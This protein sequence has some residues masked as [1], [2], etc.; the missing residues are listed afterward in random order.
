MKLTAR[1]YGVEIE[2]KT[3]NGVDYDSYEA[4]QQRRAIASALQAEG[5]NAQSESYNHTTRSYWKLISDAS[6]GHE[7]VSP[8]LRG[9]EGFKEI[10]KVCKVL[11]ALGYKVDKSCG[12]HVHHGANDLSSEQVKAV[13]ALAIK[14]ET[15]IDHLVAPSRKSNQYCRSNNVNR[16]LTLIGTK[17]ALNTLKK[18]AHI[19]HYGS[20]G[21]DRYLKVN[22]TAYLRHGTIEFRQHQGTLDAK[23]IVWWIILTQNFLT[24]AVE[25]GASYTVSASGICFKRFRDMLGST[26]IALQDNAYV[27][28]ASKM[29]LDRWHEFSGSFG[30]YDSTLE[31]A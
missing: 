14:W 30:I 5:I 2:F 19:Q 27:K 6:A 7:I 22:Y 23:K 21:H 9:E 18:T 10:E 4:E 12:M 20:C 15:V 25:V 31:V 16:D 11:I 29:T 28:A 24:K 1:T 8:I 17:D 13:F 26:G 3:A